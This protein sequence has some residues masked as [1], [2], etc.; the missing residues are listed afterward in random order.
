MI[1]I[2]GLF[3]VSELRRRKLFLGTY[4]GD[5]F[6]T[7]SIFCTW[8]ISRCE[9]S[10]KKWCKIKGSLLWIER[11]ITFSPITTFYSDFSN[12]SEKLTSFFGSFRL[13]I[14]MNRCMRF[15]AYF[16]HLALRRFKI[17]LIFL[18]NFS[19]FELLFFSFSFGISVVFIWEISASVG[20]GGKSWTFFNSPNMKGKFYNLSET[21]IKYSKKLLTT[22][23]W[24]KSI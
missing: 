24:K 13:L 9:N 5:Q 2:G 22:L 4:L 19:S 11:Y 16:F 17:F 14:A 23:I 15:P 6:K 7:N 20:G 1:T 12:F 18:V 21:F 8:K 3:A 10:A